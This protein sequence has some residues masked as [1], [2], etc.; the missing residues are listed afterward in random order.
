MAGRSHHTSAA[1]QRDTTHRATTAVQ[2]YE[3]GPKGAGEGL[4]MFKAIRVDTGDQIEMHVIDY[5]C[6]SIVR[7]MR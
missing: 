3:E 7:G 1:Q 5:S 6:R 4:L 2:L